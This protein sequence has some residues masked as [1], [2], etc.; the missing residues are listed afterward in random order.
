MATYSNC[1]K[2]GKLVKNPIKSIFH[3]PLC[4]ACHLPLTEDEI[5]SSL[6]SMAT[7]SHDW[8]EQHDLEM[9][10]LFVEV[11]KFLEQLPDN[12]PKRELINSKVSVIC[13]IRRPD[14]F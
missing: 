7:E 2:C 12:S 3:E 8:L 6:D 5:I 10:T 14:L 9:F 13:K 4:L 1:A 11:K